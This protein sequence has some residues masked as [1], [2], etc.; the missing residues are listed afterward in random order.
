MKDGAKLT[1]SKRSQKQVA[2]GRKVIGRGKK[3]CLG[4][5]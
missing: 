1:Y 2:F 3:E 5:I 4:V